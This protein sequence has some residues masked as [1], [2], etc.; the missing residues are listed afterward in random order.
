VGVLGYES[1]EEFL[2]ID[3]AKDLYVNPEDRKTFQQLV[4]KQG[5]VKDFEVEWK[6][7]MGRR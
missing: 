7:K 5:F 2:K 3:I 6:K 1:K 4:E